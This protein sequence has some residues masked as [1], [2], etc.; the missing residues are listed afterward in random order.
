MRRRAV[1]IRC[2][3]GA[4]VVTCALII[5]AIAGG[6]DHPPLSPATLPPPGAQVAPRL[7]AYPGSLAHSP[8]FV[9]P[10]ETYSAAPREYPAPSGDPRFPVPPT[11]PVIPASGMGPIA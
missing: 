8:D 10:I 3:W 11:G 2:G 6:Q 7:P 4:A 9:I 5:L 1:I